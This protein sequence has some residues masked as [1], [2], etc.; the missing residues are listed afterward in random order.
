MIH[1][2]SLF[3]I[4]SVREAEHVD[5]PPPSVMRRYSTLKGRLDTRRETERSFFEGKATA[6][7][8]LPPA[9]DT[10]HELN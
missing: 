2:F 8:P 9:H 10:T 1:V 6:R 5:V 4:L 7:H 3:D